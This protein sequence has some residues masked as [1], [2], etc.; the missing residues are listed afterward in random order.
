MTRDTSDHDQNDSIGAAPSARGR[1][2]QAFYT[3]WARLYDVVARYTP[4]IRGLRERTVDVLAPAEGDTVVEFG[5]GTGANLPYLRERVGPEGTV[6][7][8]DFAPGVLSLARERVAR[9]G[10]ENVYLLRGDATRPPIERADAVLATFVMGMLR[11]PDAVVRQWG[12]LVGS[13]G[14]LCLLDLARTTRPGLTPLNALF[15]GLTVVSS[16]GS[17]TDYE[18]PPTRRLDERVAAAHRALFDVCRD[19]ERSLHALGFARLTAGT[20]E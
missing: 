7:G 15:R 20:V 10:W 1:S 4:G 3:R 12:D 6:V 16:P 19:R 8:V 13:G 9:H 2:A 17:R 5:C 11:D 14:R 18:T